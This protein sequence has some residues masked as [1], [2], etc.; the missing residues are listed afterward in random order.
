M[1][2]EIENIVSVLTPDEQQLLKDTINYG[3]WGDGEME[4]L[5]DDGNEE[6]DSMYGYCTN[7]AKQGGHFKGRKVSAMFR[8][9]YGKLCV[10]RNHTVGRFIS[11]CNDWW[12][13]GSGDM[14]FIRSEYSDAFEEWARTK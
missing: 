3:G 8:S 9:M 10:G 5:D 7:D 1:N 14:L 6:T 12:G 11:H 13:D 4:F 2:K